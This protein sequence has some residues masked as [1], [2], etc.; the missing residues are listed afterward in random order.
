MFQTK[1]KIS[2][3]AFINKPIDGLYYLGEELR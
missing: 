3:T 2:S 1:R